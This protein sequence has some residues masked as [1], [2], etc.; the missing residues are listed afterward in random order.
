MNA[1]EGR[2]MPQLAAP[3]LTPDE[4]RS[5]RQK[6]YV[7]YRDQVFAPEKLARLRA[8]FEEHLAEKGSKLSDELD[9]PHFRDPR[10]L[11]FLLADEVL[12]LVEPIVGP[13]I[14]L[15]SSHF[16]SKDPHTGRGT[17]WHE[18]SAYWRGR[19]SAYDNI[20]TVWLAIDRSAKENGCMRV[21][22]GS[23]LAGGFAEHVPVDRA[24]YTFGSEI[25]GVDEVKAVHFELEPGECSLHDGRI[26]HGAAPNTSPYRRT[27]YTMRYFPATVRILP[28]ERNRGFK[29]WL[30]RGRDR[31]GNTYA[32][33]P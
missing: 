14:V 21:I 20:V 8:I 6:G 24:R 26:V 23:H 7:V 18:D 32:D 22:P 29:V 33:R 1:W 30:A 2:N 9:T 31:A 16:I 28:H 3:N 10:L 25:A 4:V 27:G 15:W 19:L 5:Y 12:D 13:D 17:P 11:D